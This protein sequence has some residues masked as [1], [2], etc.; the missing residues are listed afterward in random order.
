MG[1]LHVFLILLISNY[2]RMCVEMS[3]GSSV[4]E[5]LMVSVSTPPTLE[6]TDI[7]TDTQTQQIQDM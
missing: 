4:C 5:G 2:V 1:Q 7:P 6:P 3:A